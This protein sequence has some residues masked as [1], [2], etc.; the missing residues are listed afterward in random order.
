MA[1]A[2]GSVQI[3]VYDS[4]GNFLAN[5][6]AAVDLISCFVESKD[7]D[8][9][10]PQVAKHLDALVFQLTNIAQQ[11][12]MRVVMKW[13]DNLADALGEGSPEDIDVTGNPTFIRPQGAR[14]LRIRVEDVAV[15]ERWKLVGLDI[16][17]QFG[18]RDF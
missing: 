17:G 5:L 13:R 16:Y 4:A 8:F 14:Y 18:G 12:G 7:L 6:A 9:G 10:D 11:T 15:R 3:Q 1:V 2:S